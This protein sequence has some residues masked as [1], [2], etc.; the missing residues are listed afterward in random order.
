MQSLVQVFGRG[1]PAATRKGPCPLQRE[2]PFHKI[3]DRDAS[4]G[5]S[6]TTRTY[7]PQAAPDWTFE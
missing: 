3:V 4:A 1:V 7:V 6:S 2:L 5:A